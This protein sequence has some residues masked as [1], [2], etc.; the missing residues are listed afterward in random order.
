M[1]LGLVNVD[2]G[3]S[4]FRPRSQPKATLKSKVGQMYTL[5]PLPNDALAVGTWLH[6][7]HTSHPQDHTKNTVD[8]LCY[9]SNTCDHPF[10][11][12][13]PRWKNRLLK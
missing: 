10:F 9:S 7:T 4:P 2:L 1:A 11:R 3:A 12:F 13:G 6:D 5:A 8:P